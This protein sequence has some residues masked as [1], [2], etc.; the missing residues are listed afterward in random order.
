MQVA[1]CSF[2]SVWSQGGV[3]ICNMWSWRE[4]WDDTL[5]ALVHS[6]PPT[7]GRCLKVSLRNRHNPGS[8]T[9][10]Q[11]VFSATPFRC[12]ARHHDNHPIIESQNGRPQTLSSWAPLPLR[13]AVWC[14]WQWQLLSK[15]GTSLSPRDERHLVFIATLSLRPTFFSAHSTLSP[16][17]APGC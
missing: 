14:V 11:W 4:A 10:E 1:A 3:T 13:P 6:P 15:E 16:K 12:M 9:P 2:C 17:G 8:P 5:P 7:K